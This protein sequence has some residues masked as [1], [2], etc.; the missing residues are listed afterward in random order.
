M[1]K[2]WKWSKQSRGREVKISET[3]V[4]GLRACTKIMGVIGA[5]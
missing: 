3:E 5:L 2:T 1:N 4:V